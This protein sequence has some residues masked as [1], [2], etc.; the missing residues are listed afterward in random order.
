MSTGGGSFV[1][2]SHHTSPSGVIA[3]FVKMT[4]DLSVAMQFGLVFS[5]VPGATPNNPDSGLIAYSLP[6]FPG[7]IQAI[8]SPIVVTFHPLNAG[9]GTIIAKFVLPHALGK[10]AVTYVFSPEGALTPRINMC[11]ASQPSSRPMTEAMR[12][13]RHFL[14]SKAL[15][16]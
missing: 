6:S 12:K 14:P 11:S 8:S 16:P 15:P 9:G 13:A 10:A 7:L 3:T 2:P 5:D 4:F 1:I